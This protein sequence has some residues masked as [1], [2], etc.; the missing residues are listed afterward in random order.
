MKA[1][2]FFNEKEKETI[3][4]TIA[5]VERKTAGEVAVMVVDQSDTYPEASL[6]AGL[7]LGGI[8]ALLV[9]DLF[10]ADSLIAFLP[11]L[12]AGTILFALLAKA[13]PALL[14]LFIPAGRMESRVGQRALLAFYEKG[15]YRTRDNTGVLFFLSLT[16]HKVWVLADKGIYEKI[17]PETL[18][19]FAAGIGAGI[20]RKQ[21]CP[22]LCEAIR[23]SGDILARH[24]PVKPGDTNELANEIITG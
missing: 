8:T 19:S 5:E 7:S 9:T 6:L 10:F 3:A 4:A 20:R 23:R 21:A 16:E 17:S 11:L 12:A 18:L 14:R 13:C 1:E 22:A 24:F 15:L 2:T